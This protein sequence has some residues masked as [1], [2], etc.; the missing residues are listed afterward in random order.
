MHPDISGHLKIREGFCHPDWEGIGKVIEESVAKPGWNAAWVGAARLWLEQICAELNGGY[1]VHETANFLIL[2]NASKRVA[3][4]VCKVCE[5]TLARILKVLSGIASDDGFG[6]HVVL[7]FDSHETYYGYITYFHDEGEHPQSGG[8]CISRDG[9][10]HFVFPSIDANGYG[11]ILAHEMTHACL[12]H[13]PIPLWINEALAMRIEELVTRQQHFELD[14]ELYNRHRSYWNKNTIQQFWSGESW[15]IA[16]DSFE[17]S[18]HLATVLWKK[19]E[20]DCEATIEEI[21]EFAN[22]SHYEDAGEAAFIDIFEAS[23][24]DLV[25]D[26]LGEGDWSPTPSQWLK[27]PDHST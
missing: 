11:P 18:Y 10:V 1:Q 8:M 4:D 5:S 24:G 25:T 23:L 15:N 14:R 3:K 13:L 7:M 21:R 27:P 16:G 22:R 6:K 2:S 26:F 19:I 9:Y 17:L 12:T 20:I